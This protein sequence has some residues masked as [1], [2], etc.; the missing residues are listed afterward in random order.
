M[1]FNAACVKFDQ[2]I[3]KTLKNLNFGL[4][5][6]FLKKPKKLG[7]FRSHFPALVKPLSPELQ[8]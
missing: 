6:F 4:L 8:H 2:K 7:F 3:K 5:G 1:E